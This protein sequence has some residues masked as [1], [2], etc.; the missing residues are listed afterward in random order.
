MQIRI[1]YAF[2]VSAVERKHRNASKLVFAEWT[3]IELADVSEADAPVAVRWTPGHRA[4][5]LAQTRWHGGRHWMATGK[6]GPITPEALMQDPETFC[7]VFGY[8]ATAA[9]VDAVTGLMS[10]SAS[11]FDPGEF[12]EVL[13]VRRASGL[14]MVLS[15]ADTLLFVDGVLHHEVPEPRYIVSFRDMRGGEQRPSAFAAVETGDR[16]EPSPYIRAQFRL[17][18]MDDVRD[19]VRGRGERHVIRHADPVEILLPDSIRFD[20][21]AFTLVAT[22]RRVSGFCRSGD[23]FGQLRHMPA[24]QAREWF[25]IRDAVSAAG[26][27]DEDALSELASSLEAF[28]SALPEGSPEAAEARDTLARW[29]LR[30]MQ[31]YA[32]GGP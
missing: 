17:D 7:R 31:A 13:E 27:L 19:Y 4:V 1:P 20:D 22:C 5:G 24:K 30:P 16:F 6:N 3:L 12:R 32:P 18:R 2:E 25:A 14:D 28:A 23:C 26:D 15:R 10:G 9:A 29:A 11:P 21:E 8:R